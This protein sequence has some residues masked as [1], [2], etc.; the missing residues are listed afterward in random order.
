QSQARALDGRSDIFSLGTVLYEM[1]AGSNPFVA[2]TSFETLRRVQASEYPPLEILRA[3]APR[4]LVEIVS[5]MLAKSA[6]DR[7]PDAGK[8]HEQILGF[9]YA[10]GER[11]GANKLAEFLERFHEPHG[12]PEIEGAAVFDEKNVANERTPVELPSPNQQSTGIKGTGT[13]RLTGEP[14]LAPLITRTSEIGERREVTA[15]VLSFMEG[16]R[17]HDGGPS[18]GPPNPP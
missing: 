7:F 6:D 5:R 17:G 12:S 14:K 3:D 2:P 15:L 16:G 18:K 8:L 13:F 10:T 9:F 11:F 1:I 4:P